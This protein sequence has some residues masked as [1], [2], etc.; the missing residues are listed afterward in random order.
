MLDILLGSGVV[1]SIGLGGYGIF[2]A[3]GA[4]RSASEL[5]ALLRAAADSLGGLDAKVT[6][7][8]AILTAA[9][10]DMINASIV[11]GEWKRA[12]EALPEGSPRRQAFESRLKQIGAG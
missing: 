8:Q 7:L 9:P 3:V 4:K 11:A 12:M 1:V 10:P 5:E 6:D 2:I